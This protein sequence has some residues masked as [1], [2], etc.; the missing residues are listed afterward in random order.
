M[1]N[2][3]YGPVLHNDTFRKRVFYPL[4][5]HKN[6]TFDFSLVP[7]TCP[8][9]YHLL[10]QLAVSLLSRLMLGPRE[11][12]WNSINDENYFPITVI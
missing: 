4:S 2:N 6:N 9:C 3:V 12:L 10:C 11:F 1:L 7:V 8:P 5:L